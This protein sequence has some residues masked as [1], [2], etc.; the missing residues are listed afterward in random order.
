[1]SAVMHKVG[2]FAA[3]RA[4][5]V[6]A[7][8]V[9]IAI[10]LV[11]IA[12]SAGRPENDNVTLPGTGSQSA[13]DLLDKYLPEQANGSVPIVLESST[14]LAEG[15]NKQAVDDTVKSLS[16]NQYVQSVVSPFSEQ[17][18]ADITKDGT[19]AYIAVALKVSSGDLDDDEANSVLD[20]AQPATDAGIKVSAGGYLGQQL[21]SPST[22]LSVII[23]VLA[24]LIILLFAFRTF[25]AAPLPVT[26][27]IVALA[28]GLAIV[29]LAGH[30]IDVPSIAPTLGDHARAC[31]GDGL[32]PVH[33]QQAPA[34]PGGGG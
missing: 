27:A 8:W 26:T 28:C 20:A 19:I 24:A 1:M 7:A 17:G 6:V 18:A 13:T 9:V 22:G 5:W 11:V 16:Q 30:V 10:A 12:N 23:G 14:S 15:Q 33:H 31:G 32:L 29:G 2:A 25:V 21:S 4:P 34:L 3:R